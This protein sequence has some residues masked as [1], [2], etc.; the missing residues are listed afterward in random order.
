MRGMPRGAHGRCRLDGSRG[1]G[2]LD[3]EK[4]GAELLPDGEVRHALAR[5]ISIDGRELRGYRSN[6]VQYRY[7]NCAICNTRGNSR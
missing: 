7:F 6:C 4:R 5:L 1:E 2:G 3:I